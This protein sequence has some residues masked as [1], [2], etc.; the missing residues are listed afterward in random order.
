[1]NNKDMIRLGVI[2]LAGLALIYLVNSYSNKQANIQ[3]EIGNLEKFADHA[4]QE[5]QDD[6]KDVSPGED[7]GKNEV[8]EATENTDNGASGEFGLGGNQYPKD[9]FPKDQLS[10]NDLLPTDINSTWAK[11]NP[12][13]QG[14]LSDQNFLDAGFHIGNNTVGQTLRNANRQLRSEFPNP[15]NKVGPWNQSTIEPDSN[16]RPMEIHTG[17]DH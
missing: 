1:M 5:Q 3:D 7:M 8:Y 9:C 15:Q 10:P 12:Q 4:A 2:L 16:R 11:V 17:C 6:E 13:G 14:E